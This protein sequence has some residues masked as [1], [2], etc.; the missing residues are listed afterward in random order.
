M[1][2]VQ[3]LITLGGT[4]LRGPGEDADNK[5]AVGNNNILDKQAIQ[6]PV[7]LDSLDNKGSN[8]TLTIA[9]LIYRVTYFSLY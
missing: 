3:T 9:R 2:I 7:M 1:R 4:Q 8:C 6:P 5:E